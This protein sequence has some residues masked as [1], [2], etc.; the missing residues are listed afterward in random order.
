MGNPD[1]KGSAG[2]DP[3]GGWHASEGTVL[4]IEPAGRSTCLTGTVVGE[5]DGHPIV[6]LGADATSAGQIEDLEVMVSAFVPD[7]MWRLHAVLHR[8]GRSNVPSLAE[9]WADGTP[10]RIQRRLVPRCIVDLPVHL[11]DLDADEAWHPPL[12]GRTVD[13]GAGGV[14]VRVAERF[15]AGCDPTVHLTLPDGYE[16]IALTSVVD[17]D[18]RD[19]GFDYRLVF[20]AIAEVDRAVL[21]AFTSGRVAG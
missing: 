11:F 6:D 12:P 9:L 4:L 18:E 17:I 7:A 5:H 21:S 13:L 19:D 16:V 1:V 14:R 15:P 20:S 3:N 2:L 10:E 8:V